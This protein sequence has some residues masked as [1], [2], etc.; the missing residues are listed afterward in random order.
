MKDEIIEWLE[1]LRS[2]I[3]LNFHSVGLE[4]DQ[5]SVGKDNESLLPAAEEAIRLLLQLTNFADAGEVV[6]H[7]FLSEGG[8]PLQNFLLQSLVSH[9]QLLLCKIFGCDHSICESIVISDIFVI[10][11]LAIS[12]FFE[13]RESS[14]FVVHTT[15]RSGVR[16][17]FLASLHFSQAS[18]DFFLHEEGLA[19][20]GCGQ[21][22]TVLIKL[23]FLRQ[24]AVGSEI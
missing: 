6:S 19:S 23:L 13:S 9:Q 4:V 12:Q 16:L 11:G 3:I 20:R 24:E 21:L 18:L 14:Q 7:H 2:Q 1:V 10:D 5:T 22:G 8:V 15:L 17:V